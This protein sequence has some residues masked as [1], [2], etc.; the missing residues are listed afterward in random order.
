MIDPELRHTA[1]LE[2]FLA[3]HDELRERL[4]HL[5][6]LEAQVAGLTL[7]QYRDERLHEAFE[8]EAEREGLFAWE[9]TLLLT[10]DS[11]EAFQAQRLEVHKEVAEMAGLSWEEYREMYGV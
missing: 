8:A 7:A 9:L 5:N 3:A 2:R 4:D 1:A 11:P 6:P 10:A